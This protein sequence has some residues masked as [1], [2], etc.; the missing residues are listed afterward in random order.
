LRAQHSAVGNTLAES[1]LAAERDN[2]LFQAQMAEVASARDELAEQLAQVRAE[3]TARAES[4]S[5]ELSWLEQEFEAAEQGR[6]QLA[7]EFEH[8]LMQHKATEESLAVAIL[9]N[10]QSVALLRKAEEKIHE[11]TS[12][13]E[14]EKA[15]EQARRKF[16]LALAD[17]QKLKRDNAELQAELAQRPEKSEA[18][19]P[20]LVS[21]RVERDAL[22]A[23]VAE[24]EATPAQVVDENV[25]Q[26]LSDVQR[27]F[28][29]AV[30]DLRHLKQENA[31][32]HERLA[33][34][35]QK[36]GT[37]EHGHGT[38]MDWQSQK[39]RLLA[40]LE[41]EDA[42]EVSTD[43]RQERSTIEG[44]I[45]ITDRVVAEKDR[46]I[47]EL[48][49]QLVDQSFAVVE[50]SSAQSDLL[51]KDELI[52][53]ERAKLEQLQKELHDKLRTAEMEMSV[54]RATLARKEAEIEHKLQAAQQ[55]AAD[56]AVGPDGKPR[57]KWLSALGLRDDDEK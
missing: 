11:L 24:L 38:A 18:E 3:I 8:L 51:D 56:A 41:S 25:E 42:E 5:N 43:R 33:Q 36:E 30:E 2:Q 14:H 10:D 15:L 13:T 29:L 50:E 16:E 52:A 19:S 47:A 6:K 31:S 32:L 46:E 35:S 28:E 54:Q 27:R 4:S 39:A 26:Q 34:A 12:S 53:A 1:Q 23:R 9:Q 45:S 49:A 22:A 55:A 21:L 20:E 40:T 44:T 17:A 7:A 57:R 37:T 48:R